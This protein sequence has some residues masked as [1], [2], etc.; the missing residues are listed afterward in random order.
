MTRRWF[1]ILPLVLVGLAWRIPGDPAS[2]ASAPKR[3]NKA[4]E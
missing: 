1:I 3:I 2:G 4:I